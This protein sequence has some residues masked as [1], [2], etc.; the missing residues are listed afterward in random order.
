MITQLRVTN[1]GSESVTLMSIEL[2]HT[3]V[4]PATV[5][6]PGD[7]FLFTHDSTKDTFS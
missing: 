7:S 6:Q 1:E 2:E 3:V 5:V 4:F